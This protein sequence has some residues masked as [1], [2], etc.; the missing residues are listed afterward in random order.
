MQKEEVK[1]GKENPSKGRSTLHAFDC[2]QYGNKILLEDCA[3]GMPPEDLLLQKDKKTRYL[4]MS[5]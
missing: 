2:Q 1:H 5:A 3:G 4:W